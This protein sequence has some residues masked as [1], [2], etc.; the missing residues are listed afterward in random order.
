[1]KNLIIPIL[2]IFIGNCS[3]AREGR[4]FPEATWSETGKK[5]VI[6][7]I[8]FQESDSWNPLMGTTNKSEFQTYL[9]VYDWKDGSLADSP[10][11]VRKLPY[12]VLP[13]NAFFH[14][15]SSKFYFLRGI[16]GTGFGTAPRV[17][18][19]YD[20]NSDTTSD[21]ADSSELK[22]IWS[23]LPSPDR[24]WIGV[25]SS[26]G[27]MTQPVGFKIHILD[28]VSG[29]G[30]V[31]EISTWTDGP[32]SGMSWKSDSTKLFLKLDGKLFSLETQGGV[33]SEAVFP[34]CFY[35][36]TSF[37]SKI[38]NSGEYLEFSTPQNFKEF[39]IKKIETFQPFS[40]QKLGNSEKNCL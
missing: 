38:S 29:K 23:I 7:Q 40:K 13:P 17:V 27:S 32:E 8:R 9:E 24:K 1:M 4:L 5:I 35:P 3:V 10:N 25:V 31:K 37:G 30:N 2:A 18:S 15:A 19:I 28:T 21:L 12:W 26:E 33:K 36:G 11:T 16:S 20:L 6:Y 34:E 22:N 39:E 14:E